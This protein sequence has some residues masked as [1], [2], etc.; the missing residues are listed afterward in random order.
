M[1]AHTAFVSVQRTDFVTT[2]SDY[3]TL[4]QELV[5]HNAIKIVEKRKTDWLVILEH[6]NEPKYQKKK[7]GQWWKG[8]RVPIFKPHWAGVALAGHTEKLHCASSNNNWKKHIFL[9]PFDQQCK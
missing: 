3:Y 4:L 1:I 7:S 2:P 6:D 8:S 5:Q 9:K